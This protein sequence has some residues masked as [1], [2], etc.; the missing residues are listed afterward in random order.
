MTWG[1]A[2]ILGPVVDKWFSGPIFVHTCNGRCI[3][4]HESEWTMQLVMLMLLLTVARGQSIRLLDVR[5]MTLIYSRVSFRLGYPIKQTKLGNHVYELNFKGY[6]LDRR[7][8]ILT[9]LKAYLKHTVDVMGM[10]K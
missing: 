4:H 1:G 10:T 3:V 8:C 2:S 5:N 9:M 7:L 6:T